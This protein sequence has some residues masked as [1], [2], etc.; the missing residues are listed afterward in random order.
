MQQIRPDDGLTTS[1]IIF[2]EFAFLKYNDRVYKACQPAFKRAS[3]NAKKHGSPYGMV[4]ITTPANLDTESGQFCFEMLQN[5]A[6]WSVDLFDL[7]SEELDNYIELNSKNN[8]VWVQ[9][10]YKELGRDDEWLKQQIRE[11]NGD[12]ATIKREILL[13]WPRSMDSSVLSED[14]LDKIHSF[15]KQPATRLF[16]NSYPICFYETID[17]NLNYIVSCDVSGGLSRDNSVINIIHPED[18]RIV[19][20]FVNNKIDTDSFRKLIYELLTFYFR[21]ALLVIERNS[22]GLN[23][24]QTLMKDP[25]IEPR[26]YREEKEHLGEKKQSNGFV[27]KQKTKTIAYGVDTNTATRK[28]MFDLLPEIVDT[29]YDKFISPNLYSDLASLEK[30]KNGKIEHSASGHDDSLMAYLIFR[31]A[32]FHGKC[33]R[34][35]FGISPIPSRMNIKVQSSSADIARIASLIENANATAINHEVF[36]NDPMYNYLADQQRKIGDTDNQL[37]AF[38]RITNLNK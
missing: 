14:Q 17:V 28:Q 12:T 6:K 4:I 29:E 7:T 1:N 16:I 35:K 36:N 20:D 8:F 10:S 9:Y 32:V 24:I 27:V 11:M 19:G 34:D 2:D 3:E 5:A 31:Y 21:N 33:F 25:K 23:I 30:K 15:I 38:M 37:D 26:M 18:F 22:Y 13:E